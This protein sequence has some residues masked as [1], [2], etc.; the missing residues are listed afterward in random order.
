[1]FVSINVSEMPVQALE[2][3]KINTKTKDKRIVPIP[4]FATDRSGERQADKKKAN[5]QAKTC[6]LL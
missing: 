5:K 1:M 2:S 4:G 3:I 6:A